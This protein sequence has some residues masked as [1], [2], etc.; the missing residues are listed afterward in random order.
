ML[1]QLWAAMLCVAAVGGLIN[2]GIHGPEVINAMGQGLF[3]SAKTGVELALGLVAS[4]VLWLGVFR[5]AEAAG[6]VA[7]LARSLSPLLHRLMPNVP[8]NHPAMASIGMN[9]S[10]S[11]LGID[12]GALPAGL[13]AMKDL[14]ELNPHPGQ[15]TAAQQMFLVYMTTSVT[16]LPTTILAYRAQASAAAPADVFVPL[17]LA[18]YSGLCVGLVY[19]AT[20][21]KIRLTDPV[22]LK[23]LLGFALLVAALVWLTLQVA[24]AQLSAWAVLAGNTALVSAVVGLVLWGV[25][26]RVSVFD[27]FLAGASR[28]FEMAVQLIPYLVG[29]LVAVGLLRSS[30]VFTLLQQALTHL[31]AMAGWEARWIDAIPH[32]LMKP[33]SGGAARAMMLDTFTTHGPDSFRGHLASV[34]QGAH[35]TTFYVLALCAGVAKLTHLGA[36]VTGALL[37]NAAAFAMAVWCSIAFFG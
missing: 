27:E 31:A 21:Q 18:G 28:G 12:D 24:Q 4:L 25:W 22:L 33:F 32:A 9:V 35:D 13:K 7:A 29:M 37:A 2:V 30:G 26:R 19:M 8:P 34:V 15:A 20:R 5:V 36:A 23:A 10:M 3:T 11:M 1:N 6:V 17:L 16:L 14:E